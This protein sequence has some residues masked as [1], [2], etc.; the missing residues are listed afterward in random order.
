MIFA[1]TF[2]SKFSRVVLGI[3]VLS[4]VSGGFSGWDVQSAEAQV[5]EPHLPL[6]RILQPDSEDVPFFRAI[7]E[8]QDEALQSCESQVHCQK[9][10]FLRGLAS[11]YLNKNEAAPHFRKVITAKPSSR[12]A[13]ESRF[14]LWFLDVLSYQGEDGPKLTAIDMVRRL[15]REIVDREFMVYD[16]GSKL[17]HVSIEALQ[18]EIVERDKKVEELNQVIAAL[19]KE[20]SQLKKEPA[21]RQSLQKELKANKKKVEELMS[22]LDALRRIDQELKE[23][24]PPTR[25]SEELTPS[26][27]LETVSPK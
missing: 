10:H 6:S 12:L 16:L 13:V 8:T 26:P 20:M 14:W 7:A 5:P 22:Q 9:H 19:T 27:E 23:K 25:P 11:L 18:Q 4:T 3:V 21:I 2:S 24:T 15:T 17:E 1:S